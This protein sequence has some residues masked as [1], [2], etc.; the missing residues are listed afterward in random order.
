MHGASH[1][2]VTE[3]SGEYSD[4]LG[5]VWEQ[6]ENIYFNVD[7]QDGELITEEY[8]AGMPENTELWWRVRYRDKE[9]NWSEWS[10]EAAFSTGESSMSENL[11]ENPGA[12]QG[13]SVWVIC[14]L[15]TSPS[16][17]D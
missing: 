1:W 16:P 2:Q 11:L 3:T 5:E 8:I 9:L 17:R 7:T 13:M 12:E 10:D 6:F 15:Y 14:L 4:P